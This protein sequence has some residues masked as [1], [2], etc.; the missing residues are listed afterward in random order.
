MVIF[1]KNDVT[2]RDGRNFTKQM[3]WVFPVV[4]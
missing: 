4:N 3:K 1:P 2:G